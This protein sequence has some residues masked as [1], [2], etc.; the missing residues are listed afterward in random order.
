ML[1]HL[2]T[3]L[4]TLALMTCAQHSRAQDPTD[5]DT[6]RA[7]ADLETRLRE[8]HL[9]PEASAVVYDIDSWHHYFSDKGEQVT[10]VDEPVGSIGAA[11]ETVRYFLRKGVFT[12]D[13]GNRPPQF[14]VLFC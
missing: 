10:F 7:I 1:R 2:S 12:L 11:V 3:I 13:W 8:Q 5:A 9:Q 6:N 14:K 4:L